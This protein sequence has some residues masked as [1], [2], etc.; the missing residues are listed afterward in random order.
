MLPATFVALRTQGLNTD[1]LRLGALGCFS[2]A[3][4]RE[5][6]AQERFWSELIACR[7]AFRDAT[8]LPLEHLL[9]SADRADDGIDNV[10]SGG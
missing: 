6:Q 1:R 8:G 2:A 9:A 5:P 3:A 7:R 4:F 10:G